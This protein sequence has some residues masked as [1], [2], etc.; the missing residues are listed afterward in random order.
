[1][2]YQ[3]V[4]PWPTVNGVTPIQGETIMKSKQWWTAVLV[5]EYNGE[6]QIAIYN[7]LF[8]NGR[9]QQKQKMRVMP[10]LWPKMKETL[11]KLMLPVEPPKWGNKTTNG[12]ASKTSK[13][14]GFDPM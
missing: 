8:K 2:V 13:D 4:E 5:V 12:V 9:W 11:D 1:M 7:W 3:N 14:K 10:F 6:K